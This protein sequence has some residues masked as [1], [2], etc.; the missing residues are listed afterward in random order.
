MAKFVVI[1]NIQ[2]EIINQLLYLYD[3]YI[4]SFGSKYLSIQTKKN[5]FKLCFYHDRVLINE[6]QH[7]LTNE[8]N[9]N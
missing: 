8:S 1:I 7:F 2:T 6:G 5:L 9:R 3:Q 4:K